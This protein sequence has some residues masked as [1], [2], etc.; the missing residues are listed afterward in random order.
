LEGQQAEEEV[1]VGGDG[2]H[3]AGLPEGRHRR[4]ALGPRCPGPA[5]GARRIGWIIS[6]RTGPYSPVSAYPPSPAF[7]SP[8]AL[9]GGMCLSTRDERQ[10]AA[11]MRPR[12]PE[13]DASVTAPSPGCMFAA[14]PIS[15]AVRASGTAFSGWYASTAVEAVAFHPNRLARCAL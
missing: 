6:C 8:V 2:G 12:L 14:P 3:G 7:H 15:R 9:P 13:Q 1:A 11:R 4:W 10:P 5:T